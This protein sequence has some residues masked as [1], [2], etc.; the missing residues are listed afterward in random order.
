MFQTLPGFREFYPEDCAIRNY[1]FGVWRQAAL[2]FA[3]QEFDGPLL[4]PLELITAKS[5]DEIVSQL[6]NFEDKG[7][8]AVTLRPELTPTLARLV[9]AKAGSIKR[10]VKWFGIAENFR[11][12]KP[13][14][15]RLRSH[16]QL[17]ADI[18]G[19]A[20]P[21]AD[22]E[23][24][25][26]LIST[27][28]AFGLGE[29]E[30]V[31]RLSDRDL[32]LLLLEQH[33]LTGDVATGALNVIDK[34]ERESPETL[35]KMMGDKGVPGAEAVLA[36]AQQLVACTSL[37]AVEAF[38]ADRGGDVAS[39]ARVSARLDQWREVL[40]HLDAMGL[41]G[42][43]RVDLGIVRGLAYYTGFVFEAFQTVG[44]GRALAGGGRY[45][46]L[47]EKLGGQP[48]PAVGFGMG[49][50]TL[51]DLLEDCKLLPD[52]KPA[53]DGYVVVGGGEAER[54]A[55]LHDVAALR[56]AGFSIDHPLKQQG[57]G[58]Q[59]KTAGA[60]GARFA[61]IYGE[62]EVAQGKLKLRD[63]AEGEEVLVTLEEATARLGGKA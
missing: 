14:K 60:S 12:E 24:I 46:H 16:Y 9:G 42:F 32:W 18:L 45:D 4:E 31:L 27:L 5:G 43:I 40:A 55:A 22:A 15:G 38:F 11:Y 23:V 8:R 35:L 37:E 53:L 36:D 48:M 28:C 33:G 62:E 50:V 52:P 30:F 26:L 61:L 54:R 59:F 21:A 20:S 17:N 25:A 47:V 41:A 58:K 44:K 19:E 49:D 10:P 63:L 56:R 34:M 57:F 7:G 13:Q 29:R 39:G 2:R 1:I 3:F 51:R 6:F